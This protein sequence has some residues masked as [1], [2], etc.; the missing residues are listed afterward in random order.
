MKLKKPFISLGVATALGLTTVS[1]LYAQ[2]Q[3]AEQPA[4]Q[5]VEQQPV[6]QQPAEPQPPPPVET[7]PAEQTPPPALPQRPAEG[8]IQRDP[9]GAQ[10]RQEPGALQRDPGQAKQSPLKVTEEDMK[11][12]V[13]E[14]NK[15]SKF[16]GMRVKN[17]QD[18]NLGRIEDLAFELESGQIAY[19]V[20]GVGGFLGLGEKYIAVPLQALTPAQGEDHL[21]LDASKQAVEQA[22]G[23]PK[24]RWPDLDQVTWE[25]AAGLGLHEGGA[26]TFQG[27]LIAVDQEKGMITVEGQRET[28]HFKVEDR[29]LRGDGQQLQGLQVGSMVTVQFEQENG[30]FTARKISAGNQAQGQQRQNQQQQRQQQQQ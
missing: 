18:E 29:A 27:K 8:E 4:Q 19:A 14:I 26:N 30:E 7:Q 13:T 17:P 1:G 5:P 11:K 24:D 15:A 9:A 23:F 6:E 25:T 12:Q 20:I 22:K 10:P 28:R 3:P 2:E 21:L 16:I